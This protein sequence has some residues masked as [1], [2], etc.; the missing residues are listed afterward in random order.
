[1]KNKYCGFY[2]YVSLKKIRQY[3]KM[4][5]EMKLAWLY[6]AN[7]LRRAYPKKIIELQDKF[8]C[9]EI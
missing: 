6:Q 7:I 3:Q 5:L 9:G 4:P 8:R 1:M 2:Y